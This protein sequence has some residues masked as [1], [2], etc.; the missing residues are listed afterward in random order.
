MKPPQ[1]LHELGKRMINGPEYS[2]YTLS[3]SYNILITYI[4]FV[5][6]LTKSQHRNFFQCDMLAHLSVCGLTAHRLFA[7]GDKTSIP[8][9]CRFI[10]KNKQTIVPD[11]IQENDE[12]WKFLKYYSEENLKKSDR[13]KRIKKFRDTYIGHSQ[14]D[15][16][17]FATKGL[18]LPSPELFLQ[19]IEEAN[20]FIAFVYT[21]IFGTIY[22]DHRLGS[23]AEFR[24]ETY[25]QT[26]LL[27][28]SLLGTSA[29]SSHL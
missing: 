13:F 5:P 7:T 2:F 14:L 1:H 10:K 25:N 9:I 3:N 11:E 21:Y 27:L 12:F 8:A 19:V 29:S 18:N 4:N 6:L 16:A 22:R 24:T 23:I 26:N 15:S 17:F 28:E 20:E